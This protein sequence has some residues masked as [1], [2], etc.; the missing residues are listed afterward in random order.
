MHHQEHQTGG[1]KGMKNNP[2]CS[3]PPPQ[4]YLLFEHAVTFFN[5]DFVMKADDDTFVNIPVVLAVLA[6]EHHSRSAIYFGRLARAPEVGGSEEEEDSPFAS[7]LEDTLA[8]SQL[9]VYAAGP[10]YA[11]SG[12]AVQAIVA[13]NNLVGLRHNFHEDI[14]VGL[15]LSGLL[16]RFV[17]NDMAG[18]DIVDSLEVGRDPDPEPERFCPGAEGLPF[19]WIHGLKHPGDMAHVL[20]LAQPCMDTWEAAARTA[21][22]HG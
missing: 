8:R 20:A 15:W 5:P 19:A 22:E 7:Y 1:T 21:A 13:A 11:L 4:V 18:V 2:R 3:V 9:P 16:V 6:A 17:G 12:A 14:A 10:G